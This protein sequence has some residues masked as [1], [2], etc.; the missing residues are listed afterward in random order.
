MANDRHYKSRPIG[1]VPIN[2][3][4]DREAF[5]LL[6]QMAPTRKSYG[7]Y[8]SRLLYEE[9]TRQEERQRRQHKPKT[10]KPDE[11]QHG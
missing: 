4:L 1:V 9:R 8:L 6:T 10:A 7:R 5:E 11:A 2:T 3:S